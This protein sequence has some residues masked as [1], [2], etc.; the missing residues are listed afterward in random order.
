M[1]SDADPPITAA[2]DGATVQDPA[3]EEEEAECVLMASQR[4]SAKPALGR[5]SQGGA[6]RW[7]STQELR[8]N[9]NDLT[10]SRSADTDVHEPPLSVSVSA[11]L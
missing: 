8:L 10:R 5:Q 2:G 9:Q 7:G 4:A 1:R 3:G 6:L 11:F